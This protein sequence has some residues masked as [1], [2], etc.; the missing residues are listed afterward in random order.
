VEE[1]TFPPLNTNL[2][3]FEYEDNNNDDMHYVTV[4]SWSQDSF[5]KTFSDR[6]YFDPLWTPDGNIIIWDDSNTAHL[7]QVTG[8]QAGD[9]IELFSLPIESTTY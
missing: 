9:P 5:I 1:S 4:L 2:L 7:V 3:L 6:Q 8:D